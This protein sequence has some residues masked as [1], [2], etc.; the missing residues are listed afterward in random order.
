[1]SAFYYAFN[2]TSNFAYPIAILAE[3]FLTS[4]EI[5]FYDKILFCWIFGAFLDKSDFILQPRNTRLIVYSC[6]AD[7]NERFYFG[8]VDTKLFFI[9]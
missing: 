3:F 8:I 5:S 6:V 4:A 9:N 7:R 1:M 2:V